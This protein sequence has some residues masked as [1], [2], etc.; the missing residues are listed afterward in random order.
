MY[1]YINF[2]CFWPT[3]TAQFEGGSDYLYPEDAI[4]F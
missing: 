3:Y 1:E 2:L 4:Y